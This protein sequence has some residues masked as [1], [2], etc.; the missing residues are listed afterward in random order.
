MKLKLFIV[1]ASMMLTVLPSYAQNSLV[2]YVATRA[3]Y[4]SIIRSWDD[5]LILYSEDASGQGYFSLISSMVSGS[6]VV[7]ATVPQH[8]HIHDFRVF[9][10]VVYFGGDTIAQARLDTLAIVGHFGI[11]DVFVH[12]GVIKYSRLMNFVAYSDVPSYRQLSIKRIEAYRY[13]SDVHVFAVGNIAITDPV[14]QGR[15]TWETGVFDIV[16]GRGTYKFTLGPG[17]N[18]EGVFFD[19]ANTDNYLVTAAHKGP[20]TDMGVFGYMLLRPFRKDADP[21]NSASGANLVNADGY[22]VVVDNM[23]AVGSGGDSFMLAYAAL[24]ANTYQTEIANMY[25]DA[26]GTVMYQCHANSSQAVSSTHDHDLFDVAF[27]PLSRTFAMITDCNQLGHRVSNLFNSMSGCA[28][29]G[30]EMRHPTI[31]MNSICEMPLMKC[32]ISG[33]FPLGL[34]VVVQDVASTTTCMDMSSIAMTV[35]TKRVP[36]GISPCHV[37]EYLLIKRAYRPIVSNTVF[38]TTCEK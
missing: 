18:S 3:D 38:K 6:P 13:G 8:V 12:G 27:E 1:A 32:A 20:R 2:G 15:T 22:T 30:L 26:T 29:S 5:R 17:N 16:E 35:G 7:M 34:G 28:S 9:E 14:S 36:T 10:G 21:L 37:N 11:D 19:I 33:S 31:K 25:V 4:N 23:L 24:D